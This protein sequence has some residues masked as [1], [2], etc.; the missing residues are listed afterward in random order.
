MKETLTKLEP[1]LAKKSK[2]VGEL[3]I[4]LEKEQK[5]ADKVA[6]VVK[7]DEEVAKVKN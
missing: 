3:M 6:E 4:N 7:A 2:E 1:I 5:Q